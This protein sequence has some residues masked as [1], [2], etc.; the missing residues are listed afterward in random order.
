M[1]SVD[2]DVVDDVDEMVRSKNGALYN[3]QKCL[4]SHVIC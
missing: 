3:V 2:L 1:K 4:R